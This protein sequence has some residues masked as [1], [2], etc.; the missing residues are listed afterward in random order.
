MKLYKLFFSI[1][2]I[3]VMGKVHGQ[4]L[5]KP[6][7]FSV[8]SNIINLQGANAAKGHNFGGPAIGISKHIS[9][10]ISLGTQFS[11]GNANNLTDK[12]YVTASGFLG[13]YRSMGRELLFTVAYTPSF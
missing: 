2:L 6:W 1:F 12:E 3:I 9:S 11:L 4:S 5:E 10:G 13:N 8:N 7:S